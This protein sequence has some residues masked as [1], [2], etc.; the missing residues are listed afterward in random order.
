MIR[1]FPPQAAA[2]GGAGERTRMDWGL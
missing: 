2:D 1:T